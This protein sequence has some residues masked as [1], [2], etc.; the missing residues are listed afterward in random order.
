VRKVSGGIPFTLG[1][2]VDF[3]DQSRMQIF[4]LESFLKR[5]GIKTGSPYLNGGAWRLSIG[6]ISSIEL[7]LRR[8]LPHLCK[9]YVEATAALAYLE[10]RITGDEFQT[11]LEREVREGNRER[12]GKR[13][14]L[15]W[16]RSEGVK[17]AILY[18]TS[19]PR[20]R[21]ILTKEEED[22][23]VEQYLKGSMGQRKLARANGMSH[24]VVRRALAR[25]GLASKPK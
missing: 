1:M 24:A 2:T 20:R 15:P 13:V 11:I 22:R 21:R 14:D 17:N 5:R 23:L 7:V 12:V 25:R 10:D 4:M 18:S 8:M 19:F 9:K 3:I 16:T 6:N